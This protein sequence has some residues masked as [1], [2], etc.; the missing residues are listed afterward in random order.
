M[1]RRADLLAQL[2]E[3]VE[4]LE[5]F[6]EPPES[7]APQFIAWVSQVAVA[8]EGA[9]MESE[10]EL[11][12]LAAER[13]RFADDESAMVT[14]IKSMK[15]IL[16]GVLDRLEGGQPEKPLFDIEIV[17]EARSYVR[18]IASQAIGCYERGWYDACMVMVRRLLETLIIE[19]YE[20]H[21][22]SDRVKNNNGDYVFLGDLIGRFVS[23]TWHISRNTRSSLSKLKDIKNAA[24][25]A[26]HNRRILTNRQ[27]ID[28]IEKDLRICIQ[29]LVYIADTEAGEMAPRDATR[30]IAE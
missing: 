30:R 24:D 21:G 29:E 16:L 1:N 28:R 25:M 18:R 5:E 15:S 27:D 12:N 3:G 19:C 13:V 26:A 2:L 9:G 20:K 7:I 4:V 8:L 22:L 6:H 11:W 17:A 14:Q 10:L 23:E